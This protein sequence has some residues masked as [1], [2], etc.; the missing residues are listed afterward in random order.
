[1]FNRVK[2][3]RNYLGLSQAQF[4]LRIDRAPACISKIE[5]GR[6]KSISDETI[7]SICDAFGVSRDWLVSGSGEMFSPGMEKSRA[8]KE[9]IGDRIKKARKD[10]GLT[11]EDL[12]RITGYSATHIHN[13]E[14][15][16]LNP[17]KNFVKK[18]SEKTGI[19]YNWLLTG[20]GEEMAAVKPVDKK[21]INWLNAHTEVLN[22]LRIRAGLD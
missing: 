21:L 10:S 20:E 17:S 5:S 3:I 8:D 9:G 2:Q 15:H 18:M 19:S 4:A 22:E 14:A 16:K 12:S 7:D 1:M 11:Q 13:V 6:N